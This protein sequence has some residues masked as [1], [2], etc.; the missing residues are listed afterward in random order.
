MFPEPFRT[1]INDLIRNEVRARIGREPSGKGDYCSC[2]RKA[3]SQVLSSECDREEVAQGVL[4]ELFTKGGVSVFD[5]FDPDKGADFGLFIYSRARHRALTFARKQQEARL[6]LVS[7]TPDEERGNVEVPADEVS[8][9]DSLFYDQLLFL[10]D[11]RLKLTRPKLRLRELASLALQGL[12]K[13][14]CAEQMAIR[15][16]N[17][18]LRI[19]ELKGEIIKLAEEHNLPEL[20]MTIARG[21]AHLRRFQDN[22]NP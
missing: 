7:L 22:L 6:I 16:P 4:A 21:V 14:E 2:I 12:T 1:K 10:V 15:P 13:G 18:S 9:D 19:L 5:L 20:R 17:V 8:P 11:E 3:V